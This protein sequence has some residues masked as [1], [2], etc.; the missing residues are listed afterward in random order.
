MPLL[1]RAYPHDVL[2]GV[3]RCAHRH[4][5][6]AIRTARATASHMTD[7]HHG[8][9]TE[10]RHPGIGRGNSAHLPPYPCAVFAVCF[11]THL[12]SRLALALGPR[13]AGE[14]LPRTGQRLTTLN[15][16]AA[17][18]CASVIGPASANQKAPV[19]S[20]AAPRREIGAVLQA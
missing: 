13:P 15:H 8:T 14:P 12:E 7:V 19:L 18:R 3:V 9:E 20:G 2:L 17:R 11:A 4:E 10:V 5:V 6:G 1:E 16:G